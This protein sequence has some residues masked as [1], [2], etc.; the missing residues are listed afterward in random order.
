MHYARNQI[1]GDVGEV[2]PR[3][4]SR[5]GGCS[6]RECGRPIVA[7]RLC[8]QHYKRMSFL[9]RTFGMTLDEFADTLDSQ[10]GRCAICGASDPRSRKFDWA[11][12][13]DH[14]TGRVRGILCH[15]CNLGLGLFSDDEHRL[16]GA[17]D[18]LRSHAVAQATPRTTTT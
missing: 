11:V 18:Y 9:G 14:S 6:F 16:L 12:D 5:A 2:G 17:I 3:M 8:T 7:K 4:L 1:D 10:D 13:H 15:P